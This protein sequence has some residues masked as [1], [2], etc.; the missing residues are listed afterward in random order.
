MVR[1][2]LCICMCQ[3]KTD[4][5]DQYNRNASTQNKKIITKAQAEYLIAYRARTLY[6]SLVI[7]FLHVCNTK[8]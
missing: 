2:R 8:N 6:Y 1:D 3:V 7:S 4:F 5:I